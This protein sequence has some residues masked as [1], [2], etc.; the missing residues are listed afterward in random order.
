MYNS[1]ASIKSTADILLQ[2]RFTTA[3]VDAPNTALF[4]RGSQVTSQ[5]ALLDMQFLLE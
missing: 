2:I 3:K 1:Y 4:H 5:L